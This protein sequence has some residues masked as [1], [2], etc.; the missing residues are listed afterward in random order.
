MSN[1]AINT[2]K[3]TI[4][5]TITALYIVKYIS[6]DK[7]NDFLKKLLEATK[8]NQIF[9]IFVNSNQK[10]EHFKAQIESGEILSI[11]KEFPDNVK[12]IVPINLSKMGEVTSFL[13]WLGAATKLNSNSIIV[14]NNK[15]NAKAGY[16]E[17]WVSYWTNFW[18]KLLTGSNNNLANSEWV[19]VGKESFHKLGLSKKISSAWQLA[20]IA[21]KDNTG[22]TL[23]NELPINSYSFG[24]GIVAFFTSFG[25][26]IQSIVNSFFKTASF[27]TETN[28]WTD[29]NYSG[30]KKIF[31]F[32]AAILLALMCYISYDYNVTWD[33]PNHNTYSKDV[34]KYYK[35]MGND[36]TMFDFQKA[37]HRDYF[38]NVLYGMSIDVVSSAINDT[39]GIQNDYKTRHLL[40]AIIGFLAILFSALII[41]R[42]SGW[43]PAIIGLIALVCS[44]SFFGHCFNNPK[45]IPFAAG[46]VMAI[47][48]LIK[49]IQELPNAK[50]QTKVMLAIAI[51][52]AIS[53]RVQGV[54][55]IVYLGL[56]VGL[57]WL[58]NHFKNKNKQI[59]HFA[60]IILTVSI[61]GFILG[62]LLWPYALRAPLSAPL[63]ALKEFSNFNYLTYYELFDGVRVFE[64]P[65]YYEPKLIMLTA[66]LAI[67]G[68]F[69]LG[70]LL[71]WF[72][73]DKRTLLALALLVFATLFPAFYAIYQKSYVYNGWRHFIFIYPSLV[74][75]AILGW[76]WLAQLFGNAKV[77][78]IVLALIA[79]SF[80]K[81]GIWSIVNHPYQY[82][83][84]NELA[85]GVKGANGK[86]EL[87][88]WN[89]SPREAFKWL[90]KNKPEILKGDVMV[91]S[92]NI[93]EALK[94]FVPEGKDV[95][96]KWT[97]EYE[98]ANDDWTYAIWTTR[99]L[100]K[101]QI[102][103][104]N[105]PP[106]GTIHE[107]KVDGVTIAAVVKSANNYSFLANNY[108]KKNKPDSAL[109]FYEKAYASN[110]NDEEYARGLANACKLTNKLD[111]ALNF[112]NK[113]LTLRDGNYEAYAGI[114]EVYFLKAGI[115]P[116]NPDKAI[117]QKAKENFEKAIYYKKNFSGAFYYLSEVNNLLGNKEE[118][119]KSFASFFEYQAT[120]ETYNKFTELLK[121]NG[122]SGEESEPYLYMYNKAIEAKDKAKAENF[123]NMHEQMMNGSGN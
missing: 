114:G 64:K 101:N 117:L 74:A 98:W 69:I 122:Y 40:N 103:G 118:A 27:K 81:P 52:F 23:N 41:R 15:T 22:E 83:Y 102:L 26:G 10:L 84:F 109:L 116:T 28:N 43:L 39:F 35:S 121:M 20:A 108:I 66:P 6:N 47:Y 104:G 42:F 113:V 85:G 3:N 36:T 14:A 32:C 61:A 73:K 72:K 82:M 17:K 8:K 111:S 115:N 29:I 46:Y 13:K 93:Q 18:P 44:P 19:L 87:D 49:L 120:Q 68:G 105:W 97:R 110:I 86:Y 57:Y 31:G 106:K 24:N 79:V 7:Q 95:K 80:L 2:E 76:Y 62:I 89:Q 100:S 70:L 38:T 75:L 65:W 99:T 30:Y 90:V 119:L 107:V 59:W 54:L 51:G 56:F 33:E 5:E 55:P 92:N 45:D 1:T 88:Y 71:G 91:S 96:Y 112:Y 67:L 60:K 50:H 37:G 4:N 77:K 21:E 16:L 63:K 25:K 58:L 12:N 34:L 78:L 123:L 48:Y 53:I 11:E 94:T 9:Q